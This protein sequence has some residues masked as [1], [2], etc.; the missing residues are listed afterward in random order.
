[1][2]VFYDTTRGTETFC[3]SN[4]IVMNFIARTNSLIILLVVVIIQSARGLV[5]DK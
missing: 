4:G 2:N 3:H 5:S 1:M